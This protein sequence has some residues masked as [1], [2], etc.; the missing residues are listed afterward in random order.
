M[1]ICGNI[2]AENETGKERSYYINMNE[3]EG[4]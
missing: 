2:A 3:E 1:P 4:K